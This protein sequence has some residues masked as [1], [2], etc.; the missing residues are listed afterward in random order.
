[1]KSLIKNYINDEC[2]VDEAVGKMIFI[3]ITI[4][5]AMGVGWWIW[6]TLQSRTEKS[7]CANNP[8]PWCVE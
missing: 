1:M 7:S 3:I 5:C 6:N 2:A 4:T 8:S